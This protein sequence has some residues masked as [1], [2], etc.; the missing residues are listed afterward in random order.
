MNE[1]TSANVNEVLRFDLD[2][3]AECCFRK[4]GAVNGWPTYATPPLTTIRGM[5]YNALGR[6]SLLLQYHASVRTMDKADVDTE[7]EFR[8]EFE[9]RTAIGL[10]VLDAGIPTTHFASFHKRSEK[11]GGNKQTYGPGIGNVDVLVEPTFRV[12]FGSADDDLL[13]AVY[14]ALADP[15]R[16]LYLGRS[17]DLVII[18][19]LD[20]VPAEHIEES[21]T[22]DCVVPGGNANA[23]RIEMLPTRSET[24]GR[25]A[26]AATG[27][28]VSI[29]G[30]GVD[31]YYSIDDDRFV[32]IDPLK[33]TVQ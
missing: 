26:N 31:S 9:E 27:R 10:R 20:L 29:D 21:A 11:R 13:A 24:I 22:L 25:S 8:R 1:S 17:D 5:I 6:P 12:Y 7:A 15:Q 30:G 23:D 14:Q 32:F 28:T 4:A 19:D 18:D 16:P 2:V 33:G 3:P